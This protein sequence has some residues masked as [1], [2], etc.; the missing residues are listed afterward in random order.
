MD[1]FKGEVISQSEIAKDIFWL[2]L[3]VP[4][5]QINPGQFYMLR[6]WDSHA[7][8]LMRPISIYRYEN[9]I[10][11]F[12]YRVVGRGTAKLSQLKKQDT[13]ELL[14]ALGNG[15][16]CTEVKGEIALVGGGIGIPPLYE[17]AKLL[18]NL[19]N[20][21]D[22]YLGYKDDLFLI[23]EFSEIADHLF[24]ACENG[25]EGYP[26][27]VTEIVQKNKYAAIFTCGPEVMMFNLLKTCQLDPSKIWMSMEKRMACGIGA[28]LTCNCE[29]THGMKRCCKDGPVFKANELILK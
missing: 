6:S 29:T 12:L 7:L 19:G 9:G 4:A 13:V 5:Q 20:S 15:F 27:F 1:Y 25:E 16:P 8:P 10:L 22:V 2:R 26:G 24:I 23:E 21:V 18:K 11:E 14:G 3:Q 28:C 17:T